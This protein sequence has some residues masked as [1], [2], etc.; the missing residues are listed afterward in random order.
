MKNS[1]A[2]G[3]KRARRRSKVA[4]RC[5]GTRFFLSVAWLTAP[6]RRGC[7]YAGHTEQALLDCL[8]RNEASCRGLN[9]TFLP[10]PPPPFDRRISS[11]HVVPERTI[12]ENRG[13]SVEECDHVTKLGEKVT[14]TFLK[15]NLFARNR[16]F[17][18]RYIDHFLFDCLSPSWFRAR[19]I[20]SS[21]F[22]EEMF[23]ERVDILVGSEI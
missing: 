14:F 8:V 4:R 9:L 20:F 10:P 12:A 18:G 13:W 7:F 21:F 11:A 5:G 1:E 19:K 3:R 15:A 6:R 17:I 2:R 22:D 23:Q 16:N